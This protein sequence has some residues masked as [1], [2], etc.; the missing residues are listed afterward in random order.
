MVKDI[1]WYLLQLS[2][3]KD[4]KVNDTTGQ[5]KGFEL[6]EIV[7]VFFLVLA[8]IPEYVAHVQHDN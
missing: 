6:R 4:S 1:Q 3:L 7:L 8:F 2:L 5:M